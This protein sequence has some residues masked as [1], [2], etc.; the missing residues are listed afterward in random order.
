MRLKFFLLICFSLLS[1]FAASVQA[2]VQMLPTF[3][4]YSVAVS[5]GPF[6]K[7]L[8]LTNEQRAFSDRWIET[9]KKELNE[10]VNFAGHYRFFSYD[11][12][13]GKECSNGGVCGWV[14]D[15]ISG[16]VISELPAVGDS[17]IYNQVGDNGTPTGIDFNASFKKNSLLFSLTAQTIPKK[18]ATDN[19]GYPTRPPCETNY[20]K[21]ENDKFINVFEDKNGCNVD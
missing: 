9:A 17:N 15:K 14:I 13:N 16:Q 12:I 7:S 3:A 1:S 5:I 19:N 10:K 20:Y 4:D 21:F 11:G 2:G 18:I 8:V 6:S